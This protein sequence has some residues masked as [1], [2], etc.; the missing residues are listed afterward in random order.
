[1]TIERVCD[2]SAA[3]AFAQKV[4]AAIKNTGTLERMVRFIRQG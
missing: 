2:R 3:P 1:M 4:A